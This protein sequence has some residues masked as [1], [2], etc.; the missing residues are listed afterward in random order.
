MSTQPQCS[1]ATNSYPGSSTCSDNPPS[2]PSTM[3]SSS[4]DI[5]SGSTDGSIM[6]P[7]YPSI[8]WFVII[9]LIYTVILYHKES[10][11]GPGK[12][13][14]TY[15]ICYLLLIIITQYIFNVGYTQ[16]ICNNTPQYYIA[17]YA[18]LIPW[19]LIFGIMIVILLINPG[20]LS[21]FSNSFGY[22]LALMGGLGSTINKIFKPEKELNNITDPSIKNA[23]VEIYSNKSLLVNQ[24]TMLN[25]DLFWKNMSNL[26]QENVKNDDNLKQELRGFICLKEVVSKFVWYIGTG[27]LTIYISVNY[28]MSSTCKTATPSSSTTS[29]TI[30]TPSSS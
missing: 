26:F 14:I 6:N 11:G 24:I 19:G 7:G 3:D 12:Y 25:F 1:I 17:F 13:S 27:I 21:P 22:G 2:N 15:L 16:S 8:F 9:T 28:I 23:L 20:W 4:L 30:A 5:G 10:T 29:P 18:T